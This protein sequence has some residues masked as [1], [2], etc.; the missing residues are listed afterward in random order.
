MGIRC[1]IRRLL[2]LPFVV[3]VCFCA[4]DSC[5]G[6]IGDGHI[7][8][9]FRLIVL[10]AGNK[11]PLERACIAFVD[12]EEIPGYLLPA[13]ADLFTDRNGSSS[14][15]LECPLVI[16]GGTFTRTR[17][18]YLPH[19]WAVKVS[20]EG[21]EPSATLRFY[22]HIREPI[23]FR[24]LTVPTLTIELHPEKLEEKK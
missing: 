20:K 14:F 18:V 5:T 2:L 17:S 11:R 4:I 6:G 10:D 1:S 9:P 7:E 21:Y 3:A 16:K 19:Y 8:Q 13:P 15:S 23:P 12:T 22:E 24:D